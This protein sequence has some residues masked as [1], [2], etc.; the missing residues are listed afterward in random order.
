MFSLVARFGR[1]CLITDR[2]FVFPDGNMSALTADVDV[3]IDVALAAVRV[4]RQY[5]A[6]DVL[7]MLGVS[8]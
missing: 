4:C 2:L 1:R 7:P 3:P 6:V 8:S 5:G